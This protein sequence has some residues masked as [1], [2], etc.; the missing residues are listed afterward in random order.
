M[1][2]IHHRVTPFP[3]VRS[4]VTMHMQWC[5]LIY[6][7]NTAARE[8]V[9]VPWWGGGARGGREVVVWE[10]EWQLNLSA[11]RTPHTSQGHLPKVTCRSTGLLLLLL[12]A[13]QLNI[14]AGR[15]PHFS[16]SVPPKPKRHISILNNLNSPTNRAPTSDRGRLSA[17]LWPELESRVFFESFLA[18]LA[19]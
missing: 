19:N 18:W 17:Q 12:P 6:C 10:V 3:S 1:N 11:T 15:R 7:T 14:T 2:W 5:Q 13:T 9:C 16:Y 8:R 4:D